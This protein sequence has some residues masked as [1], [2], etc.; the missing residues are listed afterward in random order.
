MRLYVNIYAV[1][2]SY[3]GPEE[4]GWWFDTGEPVGSIPIDMT[5]AERHALHL[6][7][8]QREGED[9]DPEVYAKH[10]DGYM[11]ERAEG[12]RAAYLDLYPETGKSSSVCGGEDYRIRVEDHI[13]RAY[14][15]ERPHYE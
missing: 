7:V 4:G 2:R 3:G 15:S 9:V 8:M 14:P 1:G 10:F 6:L 12:I 13:A 5:D 11:R